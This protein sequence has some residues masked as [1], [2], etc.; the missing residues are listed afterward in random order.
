MVF[1]NLKYIIYVLLVSSIVLG[2]FVLYIV[3]KRLVISRLLKHAGVRGMLV[4]ASSRVVRAKES[5]IIAA[6]IF[7]AFI[8]LRPQWGEL[9]REVKNEGSDVLIALDV[10][11]SMLARDVKP[12]RLERAKDAIKWIIESLDGD[13]AGLI[14]FA[15]DAFLQ[16]P[17]TNDTGAFLMFL[18]SAAPDS[19]KSQGTDIGRALQ[20]A[21]RV[22][23]QKRLTSR[24]FVLVTD[25]ED[26]EGAAL[27]AIGVFKELNV[28]V[29][30]VGVGRDEGEFIPADK[31]QS[32][33]DNFYRDKSGKLVRTRKNPDLLKKLAAATLGGYIDISDNLSGLGFILEIIG[34]QQKNQYGSRIVKEKKDQF[35]IFVLILI[36]L[37][38]LEVALPERK[39]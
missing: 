28:S 7:A 36:V 12:S 30:S 11:N 9:S 13:R 24:V 27:D 15:G 33:E 16:C 37:L 5:L 8:L 23:K 10:S 4:R 14:L 34:D 19:I 1:G 31:D 18:E 32:T 29:Y 2:L 38:S 20:E 35:Q 3:W 26:N 21:Y 25:G 17:L 39:K 22:F 6:I